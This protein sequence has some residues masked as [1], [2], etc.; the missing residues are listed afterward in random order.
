MDVSDKTPAEDMDHYL[1]NDFIP[2]SVGTGIF[3]NGI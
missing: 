3:E 1:R 2:V